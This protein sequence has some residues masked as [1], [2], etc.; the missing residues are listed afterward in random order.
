MFSKYKKKQPISTTR[1]ELPMALVGKVLCRS[2][3]F[4]I[5]MKAANELNKIIVKPY[6]SNVGKEV[7]NWAKRCPMYFQFP[8]F[9]R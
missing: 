1:T 3:M 5:N 2:W 7:Y 4:W 9:G 8:S 6:Q